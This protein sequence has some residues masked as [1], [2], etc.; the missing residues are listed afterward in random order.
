LRSLFVAALSVSHGDRRMRGRT[1]LNTA[2]D[3]E[4]QQPFQTRK[5]LPRKLGQVPFG[6]TGAKDVRIQCDI[7]KRA[8]L[9]QFLPTVAGTFR[10]WLIPQSGVPP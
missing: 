9:R 7:A 2:T 4:G 1:Q 10:R 5:R 6:F 8:A 3:A